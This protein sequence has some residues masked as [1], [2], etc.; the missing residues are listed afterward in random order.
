[1]KKKCPFGLSALIIA[2]AIIKASPETNLMSEEVM[3]RV[4][5]TEGCKLYNKANH[6]C[7]LASW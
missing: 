3:P 4:D 6:E 7:A 2:A 1:M 5:C